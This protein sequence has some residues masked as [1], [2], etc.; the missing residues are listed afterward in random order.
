MGLIAAGGS[1][2]LGIFGMKAMEIFP[3][4]KGTAS[5]GLTAIRQFLAFV[6]VFISEITFDGTIV[7][8]AIIL[9]SY[10]AV[11]AL[12]YGLIQYRDKMIATKIIGAN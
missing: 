7:P 11:A 8:I 1:L 6:L 3:E 9:F 4:I 5:S 2:M 10:I 12:W